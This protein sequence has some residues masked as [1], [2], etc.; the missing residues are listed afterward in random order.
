[1]VG[2]TVS[3]YRVLEKLGGGGMGVVYKA[4]DTKLGRFVALKFLP[5]ELSRDRQALERFLR[6]ARAAAA[7]NHP[8]ICT[9]YE[10]D[11]HDG[12]P[13]IAMELL[14]GQTLKHRLAG[15]PL[16]TELVLEMGS[17][18][19]DAL[20]AAHAK[21][22]IHRD[23]KP[24]NIFATATGQA[25]ILDFGLAKL[26]PQRG[27]QQ[28][29]A[30]AAT[31]EDIN[32]TSPGTALGTVAYMSPEQALGQE[33][34]ARTDI[35][36][37]GVVLYEMATG[38]QAFTGS[39]SAAIFNGILHRTPTA[40]VRLN[41]DVPVELEHIIYKAL[42]K[43]RTLRYQSA[44][45]LRADLKRLQRDTDSGKSAAVSAATPLATA[46]APPSPTSTVPVAAGDS[47]S[48]IGVVVGL[49]QRHRGVFYAGLAALAAV[50]AIAGYGLYQMAGPGGGG[51]AI[52]S[53]AV[54]PFENVGGDPDAEYLSD[55]ITENLINSL[56]KLP[57][58]RVVS[59]SSAFSFKGKGISP[60]EAGRELEVGAVL[61]GRV[62]QRGDTLVIGVEL[63]D[64]GQDAQL[65]GEQYTR[66]TSDV[67][68]MQEEIS[69]AIAG[70]LRL[71]L[72]GE[73]E[74]RLARRETENTEAYD[75]YLKGRYFWNKRTREEL[76]KGIDFFQQAIEIDP[77]YALA[78]AGLADSY[79]L[80]ATPEYGAMAPRDGMPK[81][82]AASLKAL[83]I[84]DT[85]AE[86]H[87]TL[88]V[89]R[90]DY[91]WNLLGSEREFKRALELNPRYPTAHHWYA[92]N[93]LVD[94][95]YEEAIAEI[96]KARELDPLSLIISADVGYV[97]LVGR[98]YDQA[99][100]EL[101]KTI[102]MDVNFAVAHWNLGLAYEQKAM[103][104][105]AIAEFEKAIALSRGSSVYMAAL[106]H[107][108]A[109]SER[110]AEA[111]KIV[112]Q[113]KE[114]AERRY[115]SPLVIAVV[116]AGLGAKS[117]VFDWLEKA[118][119][120]RA[121]LPT[122]IGVDPRF[123]PLRDDPRFQSLLRRLNFPP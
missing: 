28:V 20:T 11:E 30:G 119:E 54:L 66:P 24:A 27:A 69:R 80:L 47:S 57:G 26:A 98:R 115:I 96:M 107:A 39:T 37:F 56:S 83:E 21:G 76:I 89:I 22:I 110:R 59:R 6:E 4:E 86:P 114:S 106:G 91:D 55:G 108:Y 58:L 88:A 109:A 38:R 74:A 77:T 102:E 32:L 113:L 17:H 40:P 10:I 33:V 29:T 34:D 101:R 49:M 70:N 84:D 104:A 75:L 97:L 118:Y 112:R 14:E 62:Q 87:V 100:H 81:A 45:D 68:A 31:T 117:E 19:A 60:R 79:Y 64:V 121:S 53:I 111:L 51:G 8:Y 85:L 72:T 15:R 41:P 67:F 36:S 93:L 43:D 46:A 18:I 23:I 52:D 25:K 73:E 61:T 9:I 82:K 63:V 65:W 99:I 120:E 78:Y 116:Y 48:D 13:F 95:R 50:L 105:E 122:A 92:Y 1:M 71:R 42:E 5:Q 2:Q 103:Y 123:D 12:Q 94:R 3:H 90:M 16:P 44:A 7:L 35:F